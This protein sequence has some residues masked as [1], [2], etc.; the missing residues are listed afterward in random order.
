MWNQ[1]HEG[2]HIQVCIHV[3]LLQ[4]IYLEDEMM[5]ED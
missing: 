4:D 3:K 5:A 2:E 1:T